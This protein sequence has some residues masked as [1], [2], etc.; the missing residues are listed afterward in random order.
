MSDRTPETYREAPSAVRSG[1][2]TNPYRMALLI[3]WIAAGL[4]AAFLLGGSSGYD[5]EQYDPEGR[6][7]ITLGYAWAV[8]AVVAAMVHLGVKAVLW[9]APAE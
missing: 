1:T 2:P 5:P 9:K 8:V 4:Q 3:I 6:L 7:F